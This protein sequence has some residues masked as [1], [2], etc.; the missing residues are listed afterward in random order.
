MSSTSLA[1]DRAA[2]VAL[3]HAY[4]RLQDGADFEGIGRL[5]AKGRFSSTMGRSLGGAEL[6]ADRARGI[7]LHE[8]GTPRTR[9]LTTN[10]LI[11]IDGAAGTARARSYYAML[12]Q[13]PGEPLS[14]V[15]AGRYYD[16]FVREDGAW[17]FEER[18]SS[19]DLSGDVGGFLRAAPRRQPSLALRGPSAAELRPL[20]APPDAVDAIEALIYTYA[21]RIDLA[22]FEGVGALFEHGPFVGES[23]AGSYELSGEA[24]A[25]GLR[26]A[27]RLY[28]GN[29]RTKHVT[30]NVAVE[31]DEAAG[32]GLARS[33]FVA[34]QQTPELPLQPIISGR[35]R[36]RFERVDGAWRFAERRVHTDMEGDLSAHLRAG[37]A[38]SA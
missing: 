16:D 10:L 8:D 2:I 23:A 22:D 7:R 26:G 15:G 29:P 37:G 34:L 6:A 30:T 9:I 4:P 28:E 3:V 27:V 1:A 21:E 35:Y 33:Y 24:L 19:F 36:D 18:V 32:S 20:P 25:A 17:R 12:K 31:V 11:A 13:P 5:F 38:S 14:V